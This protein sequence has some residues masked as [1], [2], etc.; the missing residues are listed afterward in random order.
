[1]QGFTNINSKVLPSRKCYYKW[2]KVILNNNKKAVN[3]F[4]RE[5]NMPFL[6]LNKKEMNE[7]GWKQADF[8]LVT[9]DAYVDH[10]SFGV[11]II[12]RVLENA[13][14]RVAILSQPDYKS[15]DAFR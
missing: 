14:F 4:Y 13:G 1:M 11:A 12:S 9:G 7:R 5:K 10:P 2:I 3:A 6:P 8:I 15:C